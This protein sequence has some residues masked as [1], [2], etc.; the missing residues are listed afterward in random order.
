MCTF[1]WSRLIAKTYI[2]RAAVVRTTHIYHT[3]T[4]TYMFAL[5]NWMGFSNVISNDLSLWSSSKTLHTS[6]HIWVW[7]RVYS[8]VS[9]DI[10][11]DLLSGIKKRLYTIQKWFVGRREAKSQVLQKRNWYQNCSKKSPT[12]WSEHCL[13]N[14]KFWNFPSE[15]FV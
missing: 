12:E 10:S 4:H 5:I 11:N 8:F 7:Q 14:L 13:H 1:I 9:L 2:S 15:T 6:L 3:Q